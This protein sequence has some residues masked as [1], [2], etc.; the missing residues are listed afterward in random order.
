MLKEYQEKIIGLL[1]ELEHEI[2]ILYRICAGKY[3]TA[4][5]LWN[6]MAD[7]EAE[8]AQKVGELMSFAKEKKAIFDE[9]MTKTYT[10]RT[11]IDNIRDM[12]NRVESGEYTLL[13]MLSL[14]YDLEQS[15]IE[16]R[17]YQYFVSDDQM[18]KLIIKKLIGETYEHMS[19][20][21]K[22]WEDEKSRSSN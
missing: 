20:I 17:F 16:R 7:E 12:Q 18:V 14:S 1:I 10:I 5:D 8:H 2:S 13:K 19:R 4:F 21:R 3:E 22:A 11:V 15:I 6:T 9:K